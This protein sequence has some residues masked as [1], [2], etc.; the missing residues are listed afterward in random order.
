MK[1]STLTLL[2][3][4]TFTFFATAQNQSFSN[5]N[6]QTMNRLKDKID[7][8]ERRIDR[9][10]DRMNTQQNQTASSSSNS[11]S[12]TCNSADY[13]RLLKD[14][15]FISPVAEN[16]CPYQC[17]KLLIDYQKQNSNSNYRCTK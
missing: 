5:T 16:I 8:L 1:I 10:E 11:N 4:L 14:N 13:V 6:A 12:P 7:A 2:F 3:S 17:A 9:L 15:N